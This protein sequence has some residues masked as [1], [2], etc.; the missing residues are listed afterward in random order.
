MTEKIPEVKISQKEAFREPS[1]T[2]VVRKKRHGKTYD[3]RKKAKR[4]IKGNIAKGIEPRKVLY[5]DINKEYQDVKTIPV[6]LAF[7]ELLTPGEKEKT[8]E[9]P[10]WI[11]AFSDKRFPVEERRIIPIKED[12]KNMTIAEINIVLG[13][14]LNNFMG[15][16]LVVE[17]IAKYVH[18]S[19]NRDLSGGLATIRHRNCDVVCHFQWKKKALNPKLWGCVTYFRIG[20]TTDSFKKY[21]KDIVG[22]ETILYLAENLINYMNTNLRKNATAEQL[23]M[24]K[25]IPIETFEC[26][27]DLD[28]EVIRGAF[29]RTDFEQA[30]LN[31]VG[32]N[33]KEAL[34]ELLGQFDP[35]TGKNKYTFNEAY[36]IRKNE[37]MNTYY[38]NDF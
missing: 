26:S 24:Q 15:G 21:K 12:G 30:I 27:V 28:E 4:Y 23:R 9:P 29:T 20:K 37:L 8:P 3:T 13:F 11:L 36:E 1:F 35:E 22:Q 7:W 17:D 16:L 6:D 25:Q 5:L 10:N 31:Y 2:I 38:G 32:A 18:D 19:V 34:E 33:R 14:M